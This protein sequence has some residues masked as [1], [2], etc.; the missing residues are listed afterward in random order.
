MKVIIWGK[1]EQS[2][3]LSQRVQMVLDTLGIGD[4][5]EKQESF[6]EHFKEELKIT[7]DCALIIEEESINF[8]DVIFEGMVPDEQELTSMF[9]SIIGGSSNGEWSCGGC[10]GG[11]CGSGCSC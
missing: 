7:Q 10:S 6:D 9:Y 1:N 5:V 2:T 8:R 3:E 11:S 4:F